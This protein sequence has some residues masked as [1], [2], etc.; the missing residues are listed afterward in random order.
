M[1]LFLAGV[2]ATFALAF[3]LTAT[4]G[5][6]KD[7][8]KDKEE[9]KYKI[10]EVMKKAMAGGLCKKCATGKGTDEDKKELV[11]LFVALH[12]NTP[13][14]GEKEEWAKITKSFVDAAKAILDGK[15]EDAGKKLA[16]LVNCKE[17]HGM[18]KK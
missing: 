13:P 6:G 8:D 10:K 1:K 5:A 14:K 3:V 4:D 16:K 17:C 2:L 18:F 15:D 7:K 9:P 12:A 11:E